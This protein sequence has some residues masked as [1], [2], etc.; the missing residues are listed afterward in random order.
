[1]GIYQ[2][3]VSSS[4]NT[5][6]SVRFTINSWSPDE[7]TIAVWLSRWSLAG[8]DI[9]RIMHVVTAGGNGFDLAHTN[10]SVYGSPDW[11]IRLRV[12]RATTASD[13][14]SE[15]AQL[16]SL[17]PQLLIATYNEARSDHGCKLYTAQLDQPVNEL[18]YLATGSTAGAGSTTGSL[19][20]VETGRASSNVAEHCFD[21]QIGSFIVLPFALDNRHPNSSNHIDF[22]ALNDLRYSFAP[23]KFDSHVYCEFD[24][25]DPNL[26]PTDLSLNQ[27]PGSKPTKAPDIA[28][29]ASWKD[30]IINPHFTTSGF[31]NLPLPSQ[32]SFATRPWI[33]W[34]L[35]GS[36]PAAGPQV[37][38]A[39]L[40]S[41][42]DTALA[43]NKAKAKA[44]ALA[45]S[46]DSALVATEAKLRSVN[47]SISTE[48]ALALAKLKTKVPALA[49]ETDTA[50]AAVAAKALAVALA[51][52]ADTAL[53]PVVNKAVVPPLAVE[54]DTAFAVGAAKLLIPALAVE[55]DSALATAAV[56][57]Y[58]IP[59]SSET[60]TALAL[61]TPRK[62]VTVALAVETD[63]AFTVKSLLRKI[64]ALAV[65]TDTALPA[66]MIQSTVVVAA[67]AVETDTALALVKALKSKLTA[68]ATETDSA[69]AVTVR[70]GYDAALSSE[71]DSALAV[72]A[73]KT[74][75]VPLAVTADSAFSLSFS[76]AK[77]VGL[78]TESD[79]ALP[80]TQ[81]GA[82]PKGP[83]SWH[84]MRI[85]A[86]IGTGI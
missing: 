16:P 30:H 75:A 25:A 58:D 11:G 57:L 24:S 27:W 35:D 85:G 21:G 13:V 68:L 9:K 62:S 55:T 56:R 3:N 70:R 8:G 65:E 60:D 83:L 36:S 28:D 40:A 74:K 32:D 39:G 71:A 51:T 61:G 79:L 6:Q 76:K 26:A 19:T 49:S 22:D 2:A 53:A 5:K 41:E 18:E 10:H 78:A 54:T 31:T 84:R 12:N 29:T 77:T 52:E 43:A 73:A 86:G 15:G 38:V 67:L 4:A 37:I 17:V 46:T 63:S 66:T 80:V 59:L 33:Q 81:A 14:C 45:S 50:L 69:L 72:T 20:R 48:T 44:V 82:V 23:F 1:M 47:L 34:L 42:T 7:I 64:V